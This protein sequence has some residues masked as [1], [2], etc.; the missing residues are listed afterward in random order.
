MVSGGALGACGDGDSA[1]GD[2]EP[3]NERG[4]SGGEVAETTGGRTNA[5]GGSASSTGGRAGTPSGDCETAS[6]PVEHCYAE[7]DDR[8]GTATCSEYYTAGVAMLFCT[9]PE[10]GACPRNTE[11]SGVCIGGISSSYYYADAANEG[12]WVAA[13]PGCEVNAGTWCTF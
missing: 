5:T 3:G 9:E 12:F 2:P 13:E 4:G 11:L 1:G 7:N 10:A 8:P 6:E